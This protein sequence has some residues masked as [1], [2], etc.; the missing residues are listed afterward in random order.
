MN[1]VKITVGNNEVFEVEKGKSIYSVLKEKGFLDKEKIIA[2]VSL[3]GKISELSK[4]VE[5]DGNISL[6][7]ISHQISMKAYVRSL[8]FLLIK[9]TYDLFPEAKVT[10]EHSLSKGI[11]GEIHR[12]KKLTEDDLKKIKRRMKELIDK[13][14][15]FKK[16]K[17]TREAAIKIFDAYG[18][19]DKVTLLK[20]VDREKFTL[21]ELDGRY[22]YFFGTLVYSTGMLR[23]FDLMYYEPGFSLRIPR[24][25]NHLQVAKFVEQKKLSNVFYEAEQWG[26]IMDIA[27]VGSLNK[28][29]ENKDIINIIR[30]NE[31]L[32]EKKI[33][34]IA[35]MI[36]ERKDVKIVLIA[37]PTSSGKTTFSKR[38]GIQLRVNGYLPIAISLDDYFVD[39]DKTPKHENG[40]YD[41]EAIEALDLEL[42][43]NNLTDLMDGKAVI[44]PRFD[45]KSGG[46]TW[47]KNPT[48]I[49]SNGILIVEGI[50]GLNERLT[51]KISK[52][53]KFKVYISALTQLNLDNHNRIS[54][55]DIRMIRRIVRDSLSRGYG[56][57]DTIKMWPSVKLG[58][59]KNIFVYQ[60]EADAMFNSSLIYELCVLKKFAL[61][62]LEKIKETDDE[63]YEA[64]RLVR[65]VSTFNDV[66]VDQIPDT[67]ILREF[68]GG[69][70]FYRY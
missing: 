5:E 61:K 55:T 3:N 35:D 34:Q 64:N 23:T 20:Y 40:E 48:T 19:D 67:S 42:F 15:P 63:F 37:G 46:R 13:D 27:D 28:K 11:F 58:E 9:A 49:P 41:F 24:I 10:I 12:E 65:F 1:K 29:V 33:A 26:N 38:L 69:S 50:H 31:A 39:R 62:E 25:D 68:V 30:V 2:L 22:D 51:A 59:E 54:T 45:F 17:V 70:F 14:M 16:V 47:R 6:I 56:A 44:L 60:E 7:D 36:T 21:Y 66:E 52:K 8:Q 53:N 4:T 18:M 57:K 32:H 43:N